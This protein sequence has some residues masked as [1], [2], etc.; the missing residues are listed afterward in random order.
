VDVIELF[1]YVTLP[2][3]SS[4]IATLLT[5]ILER[6]DLVKVSNTLNS[7]S[8]D[9]SELKR[10]FSGTISRTMDQLI[11]I[12]KHPPSKAKLNPLPPDKI[13]R[14]DFLLDK[15]RR[16]GLT[17]EEADEL[18]ELLREQAIEAGL[19]GLALLAFL[20]LVALMLGY[21]LSREESGKSI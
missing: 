6:R 12:I 14:R 1:L 17:K 7:I 15:G 20:A 18:R 4:L 3:L 8:G 11:E 19:T 5:L 21:F 2:I 13:K 9:L 16:E 10:D